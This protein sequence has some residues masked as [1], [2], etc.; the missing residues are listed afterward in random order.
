MHYYYQSNHL[1][2]IDIFWHTIL[3]YIIL[4]DKGGKGIPHIERDRTNNKKLF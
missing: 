4:N 3:G 1:R 2:L